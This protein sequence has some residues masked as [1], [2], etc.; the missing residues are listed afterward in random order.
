M[1][2]VCDFVFV[3]CKSNHN[4]EIG[5]VATFEIYNY[6]VEITGEF[7]GKNQDSPVPTSLF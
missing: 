2:G 1:T 7:C 4:N 5:A 6:A 3:L